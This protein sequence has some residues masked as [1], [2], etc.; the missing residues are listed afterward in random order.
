[1]PFALY[2]LALAVFVMG[3]SEFMLA[4]LLPAIAT[5]LDVTVGT[6]GLLTSAFAVGMVLG[7][8]LMAAFARRW[9]PRTALLVCLLLLATCHVV[10]AVTPV[11]PV[12][13]VARVLSALANAGFLAVALATATA[14]VP[15]DRKGR[16]LAILLSGTTIA[17]VAGVPAGALLGTAAGWRTTFWAIS[18]LCVP[19]AI[20]ILRGIADSQPRADAGTGSPRLRAELGQLR[21]HRLLL[22]MALGALVN[23]GTFAAFTFLAPVVT[24]TAGL[25][26][27]WIS[28]V[29]VMFGLGSFLGV[30][31]AGR[32]SDTR[33][34]LVLAIGG[35]LL[36][37]G[38]IALALAAS[39]PVL[40]VVLALVLGMLSFGVGSTLIAQVLYA[41]SGAPTMGGSYATAALNLGAAAGP[42]LG[43]LA[44][45][46]EA[47][48]L[49]PVWVAAGLTALALAVMLLSRLTGGGVGV[50]RREVSSRPR[51]V[52]F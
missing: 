15:E 1:M 11:F 35:P 8:P 23:G 36:L 51:E 2:M 32:L 27:A 34:G 16:A 42:I 33:P 24:E 18:L 43:A 48:E 37:A 39:N 30:T 22:A 29:L 44:L 4:G 46:T 13:L 45:T 26:D 21:S 12:L 41:A 3:T 25:E 49:A 14:L 10:A 28:V 6:A 7:A 9:P 20:G 47:A 50:L 40:L 52:S 31:V 17:T 5:D 38:W 19:A